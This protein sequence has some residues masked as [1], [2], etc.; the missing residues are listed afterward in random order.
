MMPTKAEQV[1]A[2][3]TR[4]EVLLFKESHGLGTEEK[5]EQSSS[6]ILKE[7]WS[8]ELRA[9]CQHSVSRRCAKSLKAVHKKW[10]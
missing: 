5:E 3:R 9:L 6:R 2:R 8:F 10:M 1:R 7:I 4:D